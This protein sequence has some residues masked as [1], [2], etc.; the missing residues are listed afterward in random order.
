[1]INA[2]I[3]K[4]NNGR[5]FAELPDSTRNTNAR[6]NDMR[7]HLELPLPV[8]ILLLDRRRSARGCCL[9]GCL[10][11]TATPAANPLAEVS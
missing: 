2:R 9:T 11:N 7:E 10:V 5:N 1:M 3:E 6:R 4:I 8:H